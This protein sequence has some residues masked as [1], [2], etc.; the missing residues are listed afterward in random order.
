MIFSRINAAGVLVFLRMISRKS[1]VL[2]G[3]DRKCEA[4]VYIC[5][6]D[7]RSGGL[8]PS[9]FSRMEIGTGSG[10]GLEREASDSV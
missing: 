4:R 1:H 9:M 10:N 3:C 6:M 2:Y 8:T 5:T 7:F